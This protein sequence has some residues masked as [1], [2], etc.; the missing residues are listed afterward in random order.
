MARRIGVPLIQRQVGLTR[1]NPEIFL[2][3]RCHHRTLAAADRA[4]A[5]AIFLNPAINFKAHSAA[6]A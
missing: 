3:G 1:D 4:V 5:A 2:L 6:M